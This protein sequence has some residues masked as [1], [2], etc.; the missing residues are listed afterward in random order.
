MTDPEI[1]NT[2]YERASSIDKTIKMYPGMW[3]GLTSGE[4]D[5]NIEIVFGDII[6]WLDKR[7][8]RKARVDS[9]LP[10]NQTSNNHAN[11]HHELQGLRA[12][13]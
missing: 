6:N 8:N 13:L 9:F 5:E 1:S 2:L 10:P 11:L 12:S 4:P 3:H 7:A